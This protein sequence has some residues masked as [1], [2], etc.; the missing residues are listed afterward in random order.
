M[1]EIATIMPIIDDAMLNQTVKSKALIIK[2]AIIISVLLLI[3]LL[4]IIVI[5]KQLRKLKNAEVL[6][7]QANVN[8][9]TLNSKL[10]EAN[11][12]KEVYIGYFLSL[13]SENIDRVERL[14]NSLKRNI[15]L[16]RIDEIKNIIN[17]IDLYKEREEFYRNFDRIFLKLFPNFVEIFNSYF[18]EEDRTNI[19]END[20]LTPEL[21]IFALIRMG[22]TD[23]ER[24]AKILEYSVRTIYAYKTKIKNKSIIPND[25]FEEKVMEI[26]AINY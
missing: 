2:Y 25:K 12:I 5:F 6:I 8:L 15:S 16:G 14:K 3:I 20:L 23:T 21:R 24:I 22:I 13:N 10:F 18:K 9:Q 17:E 11:K 19:K 4:F 1:I 26:R 7:K